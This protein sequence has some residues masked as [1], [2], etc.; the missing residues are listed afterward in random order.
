[1]S[2]YRNTATSGSITSGSLAAKVDFTTGTAPYLVAL[3]DI[4]GDGKADLITPDYNINKVSVLRN[5]STSGSIT[6]GSFAA[7]VDFTTG[8]NA[9][10]VAVGD[11][12]GDGKADLVVSNNGSTSISVLWNNPG[13]LAPVAGSGSDGTVNLCIGGSVTLNNAVQ[14]GTWSSSNNRVAEVDETAGVVKGIAAG[15]A[16]V[17]YTTPDLT[18]ITTVVVNPLPT[19]AIVA[20]PG[21]VVEP[22]QNVMLTAVV[23]DADMPKYQWTLNG[24]AVPGANEATY[25]SNQFAN[26]DVV[27]CSVGG[28][29]CSDVVA[30]VAMSVHNAIS[31]H[32]L[33]SGTAIHIVPNPSNG[34]FV[35]KGTLE[36]ASDNEVSLEITDMLGRTVY[37]DHIMAH[38]GNI[39]QQIRLN[40][41]EN[42]IYIVSLFS[43]AE[44][45]IFHMVIE[46]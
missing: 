37:K 7:K 30:S 27:S 33:Y 32:H 1:V 9:S 20:N 2:V 4:D 8:A 5:L 14:G 26:G 18:A 6:S 13:H 34:Q 15:R 42:G 12:D 25:S 10:F 39:D 44:T 17:T 36:S 29:S 40:G 3:G 46:R 23:Q 45:K 28:Q 16:S 24:K 35:I 21:T 11:L 31:G 41:L 22:G 43:G 19:V 38:N